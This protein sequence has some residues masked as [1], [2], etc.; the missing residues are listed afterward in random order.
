VAESKPL[1][2]LSATA[3]R[4][5]HRTNSGAE[6]AHAAGYFPID[7]DFPVCQWVRAFRFS[8][9]SRETNKKRFVCGRKNSKADPD[10]IL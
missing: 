5:C 1:S 10:C 9:L 3:K 2:P 6:L 8:F 7:H 4:V